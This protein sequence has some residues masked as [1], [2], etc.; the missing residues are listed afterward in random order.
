ML[1]HIYRQ[2]QTHKVELDL[3]FLWPFMMHNIKV[4]KTVIL[5]LDQINSGLIDEIC[6]KCL[7]TAP[8]VSIHDLVDIGCSSKELGDNQY[9]GSYFCFEY[10][11]HWF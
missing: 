10:F 1:R 5:K 7:K 3:D 9:L 6:N 8:H 2:A 4:Y 11:I